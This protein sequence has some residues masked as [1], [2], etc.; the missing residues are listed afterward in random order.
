[1]LLIAQTRPEQPIHVLSSLP[2]SDAEMLRRYW[3]VGYG[4]LGDQADALHR[5]LAGVKA[6]HAWIACDCRQTASEPPP[7]VFPRETA[8]GRYFLARNGRR[9]AHDPSCVF[10]WEEGELGQ[11]APSV[12][13]EHDA[14]AAT[15]LQRRPY[16]RAAEG[17]VFGDAVLATGITAHLQ[18]VAQQVIIAAKLNQFDGTGRPERQAAAL[19]DAAQT[20]TAD[21]AN[22]PVWISLAFLHNGWAHQYWQRHPVTDPSVPGQGYILLRVRAI[23]ED[24]ALVKDQWVDLGCPLITKHG[25]SPHGE[26]A[27]NFLVT[28]VIVDDPEAGIARPLIA[29]ALP[30]AARTCCP[31]DVAVEADLITVLEQFAKETSL[32]LPDLSPPVVVAE[33]PLVPLPDCEGTNPFLVRAAG[34]QL[35]IDCIS[36]AIEGDELRRRREARDALGRYGPVFVDHR[37]SVPPNVANRRLLQY[38]HGWLGAVEVAQMAES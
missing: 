19:K 25:A 32:R 12:S 14:S 28:M 26:T 20:L 16:R 18:A 21:T 13:T 29:L 34:Y 11:S 15:P 8:D 30:L 1:M 27:G 36:V 17:L 10:A 24:A 37:A 35:V 31:V 2:A 6:Q 38:L 5:L 33:R 4:R 7:V 3:R 9:S 22:C 23:R